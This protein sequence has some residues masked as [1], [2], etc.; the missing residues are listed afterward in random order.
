[1]HKYSVLV[2]DFITRQKLFSGKEKNIL[3]GLSGGA[4]SVC[5]LFMLKELKE[6]GILP[7]AELIAAHLNHSIR[8]DEAD[9]DE[10]FVR[11]LCKEL[12]VRLFCRKE[13]VPGTAKIIGESEE[14]VGRRLRYSFFREIISREGGGIIATAHHKN[15]LCETVLMNIARGAGLAGTSGIRAIQGD[16][17]R[18]LICLTRKQIE[19]YIRNK[20]I[21]FVEDS[22]NSQNIYT[23]NYIRNKIIPLIEQN[24][25]EGLTENIYRLSEISARADD[26]FSEMAEELFFHCKWEN[27]K[28]SVPCNK[29]VSEKRIIREYLYRHIFRQL[30]GSV[31]D[32]SSE[33]I[34]EID[35]LVNDVSQKRRSNKKVQ[36]TGGVVVVSRY[37]TVI[38]TNEMSDDGEKGDFYLALF[39]HDTR[40]RLEKGET[41]TVSDGRIRA[42]MQLTENFVKNDDSD[43]TKYFDYDKINDTACLRCMKNDDVITVTADGKKHSVRKELKDR[44]VPADERS[45]VVILACGNDCLWIPGVRRSMGAL[46]KETENVLRVSIFA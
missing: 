7:D 17:V 28:I 41:V 8:G 33:R 22:T 30:T 20:G 11:E 2:G 9:R 12:S 13:D 4:D 44:R 34:N 6:N 10:R 38:F 3:I 23:R 25:N 29:I 16:V 35:M 42:E 36:L 5:L 1:M 21:T 37:D 18:P 14:G 45:R 32:L 15:D 46:A 19:E 39:E 27:D 31:I 26:Y 43:Y 24:V 40:E